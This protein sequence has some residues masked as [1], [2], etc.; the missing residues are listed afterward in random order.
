MFPLSAAVIALSELN[1]RRLAELPAVS[2]SLGTPPSVEIIVPARNEGAVI[3]RVVTS[4]LNL[5]YP[6]YHVTVVDDASTD[7]TSIK[8]ERLG[9][10]VLCLSG[11]PPPGWTGKCN[12]CDRAAR[13]TDADWLLFTDADTY[14]SPD[15]LCRAVAYA[16]RR[17]LDALSL[18]LRQECGTFWERLVLPLA[19]QN[20]FA[21]LRADKPA[22][23]GQY[24]LIRRAV[25]EQI[26]GF[27]AVRGRVMEDVALAALLASKGY[28]IELANGHTAAS[29]RMYRDLPGLLHGMTKTAFAAARD[30]GWAGLLLAS[31]V[32]SGV[33]SLPLALVGLLSGNTALFV[34]GA[35]VMLVTALGLVAWMRRFEVRMAWLYALLNPLGM[36][37]MFG[38]GLMSTL[39]T[40]SGRGV[41]WKGRTIIERQSA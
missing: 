22:F 11:N 13:L 31:S 4:L 2:P 20:Y 35:M 41:R 12:A 40:I 26:G 25:Y 6:A 18:L 36:S 28:A 23:N 32:L 10:S 24:I 30:R 8:A 17:K 9:A 21:T 14:H 34:A 3:E 27:G 29:V 1:Y 37:L 33:S 39:R 19:Y 16:E 7:D 15:S 38:I 5:R